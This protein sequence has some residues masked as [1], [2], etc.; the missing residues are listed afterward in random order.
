VEH[1][2][3][4]NG[5]FRGDNANNGTNAAA[6][7]AAL[8]VTIVA[9][10]SVHT[11]ALYGAH[12]ILSSAGIWWDRKSER[13]R[14]ESRLRV[15]TVGS[16]RIPSEGWNGVIVQP[17]IAVSDVTRT[18][19]V[20]VPA[21]GAPDGEVPDTDLVVLRWCSTGSPSSIGEAP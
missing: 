16:R 9:L 3:R 5:Q 8:D 15:R 17:N 4:Q 6:I 13:I 12:D 20:Y 2:K 11:S 1:A 18:D 7:G 10:P 19:I 14:C 21:L